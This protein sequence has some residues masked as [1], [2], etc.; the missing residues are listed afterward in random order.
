VRRAAVEH[1]RPDEMAIVIVGDAKEV[2]P[3][4]ESYSEPSRYS[5]RKGT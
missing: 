3:Q 4:V 1:I 2:L 5:T